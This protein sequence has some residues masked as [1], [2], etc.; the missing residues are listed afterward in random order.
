MW[1]MHFESKFSFIFIFLEMSP[2]RISFF[3]SSKI[4][5]VSIFIIRILVEVTILNVS[6]VSVLET[7]L[8]RYWQFLGNNTFVIVRDIMW[9][10]SSVNT[11]M[12]GEKGGW[13]KLQQF[14]KMIYDSHLRHYVPEA[15]YILLAPRNGITDD[16]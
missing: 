9:A 4:I 5:T 15:Q 14:R 8:W 2:C 3:F 12:W 11:S 10:L 1:T 16:L 13:G 7:C 6:Q